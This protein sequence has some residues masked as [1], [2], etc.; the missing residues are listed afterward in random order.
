MVHFCEFGE[1]SPSAG[2]NRRAA[3]DRVKGSK[4]GCHP[5]KAGDLAGLV[6]SGD[7]TQWRTQ[8][9]EYTASG[10]RPSTH[11]VGDMKSAF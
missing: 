6:M 9:G 10:H 7:F 2:D 3:G 1:L 5:L 11:I 8:Q 4:C